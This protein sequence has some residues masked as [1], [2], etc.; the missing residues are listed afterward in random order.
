MSA[1]HR[2]TFDWADPFDLEGQLTE[3]ERLVRDTARDYAQDKLMPRVLGAYREERFDRDAFAARAQRH[4]G[5][6]LVEGDPDS[7]AAADEAWV[8]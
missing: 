4:V 1:T 5:R 2:A 3:E 7:D 8:D 6:R